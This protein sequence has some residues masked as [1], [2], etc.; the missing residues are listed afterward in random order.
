MQ[1]SVKLG[2]VLAASALAGLAQAQPGAA[3][4]E[5]VGGARSGDVNQPMQYNPKEATIKKSNNFVGTPLKPQANE[6]SPYQGQP[7]PTYN[8]QNAWPKKAEP[9]PRPVVRQP[10]PAPR[11]PVPDP[12]IRRLPSVSTSR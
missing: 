3:Q 9:A 4:T 7:V 2:L 6:P 12:V 11:T 1:A 5:T 8:L 10:P